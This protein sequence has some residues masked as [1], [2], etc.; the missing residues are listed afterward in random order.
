ML[1]L[2]YGPPGSGKTGEILKRLTR[3]LKEG[4]KCILLVPEQQ[5]VLAERH[6]TLCTESLGMST[7]DL[8]VLSFRRLANRI[9]REYGGLCYQYINKGGQLLILWQVFSALAPYLK[10]YHGAEISERSVISSMLREIQSLKRAGISASSLRDAATALQ[11]GKDGE[12]NLRLIKKMQDIALLYEGYDALLQKSFDDPEEDLPR[13]CRLLEL[14]EHRFFDGKRVYLDG[15]FDLTGQEY[16]LL[17]KML[18]TAECVTVSLDKRQRDRREFLSKVSDFEKILLKT[19]RSE[20]PSGSVFF[21]ELSEDPRRALPLLKV[22]KCFQNDG[23]SDLGETRADDRPA[24][25]CPAEDRPEEK[26]ALVKV[27]CCRSPYEEAE[28]LAAEILSDVRAGGRFRDHAV[29]L[30]ATGVYEGIVESVFG[31]CGIPCFFSVRDRLQNKAAVRAILSA[32][33]ILRGGFRTE[34]VIE[35]IKTGFSGISEE[36]AFLLEEY[37]RTWSVSGK[38]W[39]D[40]IG[41]TMNPEGYSD[42]FTDETEA[43]LLKLNEL[44]QKVVLPLTAFFEIFRRNEKGSGAKK[45]GENA[46]E[47]PPPTAGEITKALYSF[48]VSVKMEDTLRKESEEA[49]LAGRGEDGETLA[50][51]WNAICEA[52]DTVC[53]AAGALPCTPTLYLQILQA[54]FSSEELGSIPTAVDE[55]LF[56]DALLLRGSGIRHA[57]LLGANEGIFPGNAEED[58][59]F[60]DDDLE[61]LWK[62]GLHLPGNTEQKNEEELHGFYR[63]LTLP[64][65]R[66]TISYSEENLQGTPLEASLSLRELMAALKIE[67]ETYRSTPLLHRIFDEESLLS[68]V[69]ADSASNN[70]EAEKLSALRGYCLSQNRLK[71]KY[72]RLSGGIVAG[73]ERVCPVNAGQKEN[74][75]NSSV[76]LTQSRIESFVRC[77]LSYTLRYVLSLQ[78]EKDAAASAPDVGNIVHLLFE[79]FLKARPKEAFL[80]KREITDEEILALISEILTDYQKKVC[81][82]AEPPPRFVQLLRRIRDTAFLLLSDV[83]DEFLQSD[84]IPVCF[85]LP[86]SGRRTEGVLS[87]PPVKIPLPDGGNAYLSGIADRVDALKKGK[88]VYLRVVD[89][90]TGKKSFSKEE[91][92]TGLGLQMPLYLLALCGA[93]DRAFDRI[94]GRE[95]GGSY[96]PAG[97]LY[98]IAKRPRISLYGETSREKVIE[99]GKKGIARSGIILGDGEILRA[100]SAD[101]HSYLPTGAVGR[102]GKFGKNALS[103]EE[104]EKLLQSIP[105]VVQTIACR[106]RSG[107]A[108]AE[109]FADKAFDP[110]DSCEMRPVC[111]RRRS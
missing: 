32:L 55:V 30:R 110:C 84:F 27:L 46:P 97:V 51:L 95:E 47:I 40:E 56:S 37:A 98:Y 19:A 21:S 73:N 109:P 77:P 78:K 39:Y 74:T 87:L 60:G 92:S 1:E 99:G 2:I 111:R 33:E 59:V 9:F 41:F 53:L 101:G 67:A 52:L 58:S 91:L 89:Y 49:R 6:C 107:L 3:D 72:L 65:E 31:R 85:E 29:A 28:A 48:L 22:E 50:Q 43:Q 23:N 100:S 86:I 26:N 13:A 11:R 80:E 104:F 10:E 36:D 5:V 94:T 93:E 17:R 4:K 81:G 68:E 102:G 103:M 106:I 71:E 79:R 8:E 12:K 64:T 105:P 70:S 69:L 62:M 82:G 18:S 44:R 14:P 42:R 88:D 57:H 25:D 66:L 38:R 90:K 20:D 45:K 7:L 75:Q 76:Y 63:A 15:F 34:D 108:D 83:R 16:E 61:L 96:L 54:V 24:E 35:Y